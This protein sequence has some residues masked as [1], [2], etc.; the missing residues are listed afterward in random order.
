MKLSSI[1]VSNIRSFEYDPTFSKEITFDKAGLNLLIG[2]NASGKSN[3]V[4]IIMRIFS[5][6]YDITGSAAG[7]ANIDVSSLITTRPQTTS[8]Q[9]RPNLP[10]TFTKHRAT[11][12]KE[13]SIK[14]TVTIDSKDRQNIRVINQN[15]SALKNLFDR[16]YKEYTD[17]PF[18]GQ[19]I[20]E[21]EVEI[22]RA[23]TTFVI[24]LREHK[25]QFTSYFVEDDGQSLIVKYLRDYGLVCT[26]IDRYNELLNPITFA[27]IEKTNPLTH[28][29]QMTADALGLTGVTRPIQRLSPPLILVSVQERLSDIDVSMQLYGNN[30]GGTSSLSSKYRQIEQNLSQK[31]TQGSFSGGRS[32]TFESLKTLVWLDV[33]KKN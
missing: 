10:G 18:V 28:N 12:D 32:E 23:G 26:L 20:F 4:E 22:P 24:V 11:P 5:N 3:V 8:L 29:Y 33:A 15:R 7:G 2:P 6:V 9:G 16:S 27:T 17:S 14:L 19:R 25:E 1:A 13:S 31:T 21:S 30:D